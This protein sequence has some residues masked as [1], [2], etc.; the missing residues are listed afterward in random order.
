MLSLI[1]VTKSHIK[2]YNNLK[3]EAMALTEKEGTELFS[4]LSQAMKRNPGIWTLD[5]KIY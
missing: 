5:T 4:D 3:S 2:V 1:Q